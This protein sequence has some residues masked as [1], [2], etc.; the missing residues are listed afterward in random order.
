M[1]QFL[2]CKLI[3]RDTIPV[4]YATATTFPARTGMNAGCQQ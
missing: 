1:L 2:A 3:S 4:N